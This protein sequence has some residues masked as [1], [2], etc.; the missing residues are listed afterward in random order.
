MGKMAFILMIVSKKL[1]P[2]FQAHTIKVLTEYLLKK[3]LRKLDLSGRL[4]NWAID[5]REFNIEFIS[6]NAIKGQALADFVVE[7]TTISEEEPLGDNL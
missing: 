4:I 2:Y 7:F 5:L 6:R 3:V 1:R